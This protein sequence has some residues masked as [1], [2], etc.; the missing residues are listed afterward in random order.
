VAQS[1]FPFENI[2]TTETQFSQ[3]AR[4]IGEG[5]INGVAN[6][7]EPFA[8]S[9][10]MV[11][12]VKTGQA[13]V[14]GHYYVNDAE[15][16]LTIPAADL[17]DPR[18]DAIVLRLDPVANSIVLAVIEGNPDPSPVAPALT[19]TDG[20]VYEQLIATVEVSPATANIAPEDVTDQRE[21]FDPQITGAATTI[22]TADLTASRAVISNAEGKIAVSATTAA[23]LGFVA[24]V[25]SAIQTQLGDRVLKTNGTV[26]TADT[27]STVV[28]NITLST[29]DPSGGADGDVW[30]KYEV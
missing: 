8:D 30:L 27:S 21:I 2:D 19:Q 3:W 11:V 29:A 13:L 9:T 23:E 20:D 22:A 18:I 5:V 24:G 7:L 6:E 1:S 28:R 16:S 10:G 26:T 14:R 12:K 17:T 4:N 25:T 15:V